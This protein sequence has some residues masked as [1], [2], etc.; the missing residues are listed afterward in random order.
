MIVTVCATKGG[1]GKTTSSVMFAEAAQR[2]GFSAAVIDTDPQGSASEWAEIAANQ[3][4]PLGFPVIDA[5]RATLPR[6]AAAADADYVFIDTPP[7]DPSII[8]AAIA[9]SDLVII[10]TS[11]SPADLHR[12][13]RTFGA[14]TVPAAFLLWR[15][16]QH[17]QLYR[18]AHEVIAEQGIP[19]FAAEIPKREDIN[20]IW[21]TGLG[22]PSLY[23]Y[24][25]AFTEL[26]EVR[27]TIEGATA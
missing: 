10:T 11:T 8:D 2:A 19:V 9:V 17:T 14:L 24:D 21:F 23:G 18:Q 20:K 26:Q 5:N 16:E 1:V 13:V 3:N 7:G 12:A 25:D 22:Y 4:D 15:V 27:N 6:K